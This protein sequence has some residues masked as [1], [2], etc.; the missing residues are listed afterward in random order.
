VYAADDVLGAAL[1][2]VLLELGE[3]KVAHLDVP[4]VVEQQVE[5]FEIAVHDAW[6]ASTTSRE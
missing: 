3:T 1:L 2:R 6:M 5:R 4:L